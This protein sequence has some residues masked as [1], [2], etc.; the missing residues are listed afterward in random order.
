MWTDVIDLRDFYAGGLGQV[1]RRMIRRRIRLI[2]PDVTGDR[3]AG[4]GFATPYLRQF[5]TEAER[6]F[7]IM[8]AAQGVLPWPEGEPGL[9]ALAD[10]T[11][12][13]LPDRS[14]DRLLMIHTLESAEQVRALMRELWRVLA[15]GGRLLVVVPN[16]R[17]IW[18]RL[19]RTPFGAGRPYSSTQ[20]DFLLREAMFTPLRNEP[21]LFVPPSWSRMLMGSAPAWEK[22]GERWFP[23]FAGV[24]LVEAAKRIY[25]APLDRLPAVRQQRTLSLPQGFRR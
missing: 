6:V 11:E 18:A 16:R 1:A 14:V 15:D 10:E 8:P 23:T 22:I 13:P 4:L 21:A 12:L 25:A 7:V 5:K 3:V 17:G 20:L 24:L 9:V 2:W 19:E